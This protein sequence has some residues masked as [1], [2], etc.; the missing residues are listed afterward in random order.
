[1]VVEDKNTLNKI[2]V[3]VKQ[4]TRI[5]RVIK[6]RIVEESRTESNKFETNNYYYLQQINWLLI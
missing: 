5:Y 2:P 4:I 6:H 3:S 1:M